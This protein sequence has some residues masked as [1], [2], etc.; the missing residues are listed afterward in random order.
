MNKPK[1][2]VTRR[3]P[4]RVEQQ[5]SDLFD[6]TLNTDDYPLSLSELIDAMQ[7]SDAVLPTVS[8]RITAEVLTVQPRQT[9]IIASFGVGF[10]HIDLDAAKS[11][12]LTVT[13]TPDVL[14]DCTA[15]LAITLMLSLA[16]RA[17]EGE[18]HVRN[19]SWSGWRPTHMMA[20][21]VTGKK[22]GLVGMGRIARA[23]AKRAHQGFEMEVSFYDPFLPPQEMLSNIEA[24]SC[25]SL[26][27][28]LSSSDFISIHCP[29]SKETHHLIDA[30]AISHIQP[31]AFLI[32]TARGDVI[33]EQALV[34]ALN[35]NQIAGAA[36][37]VYEFEPVIDDELLAMDNVVLLP[38]L[39][40]ATLETRE[41]MGM[42]VIENLKAFFAGEQPPDKLI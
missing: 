4:A 11:E 13:N 40:S 30:N 34:T 2:F 31:H 37:D 23:V 22:L 32:N 36:L 8:D 19:G 15:D 12:G 14:T 1:V 7:N 29:G 41:A 26:E 9:Q 20:T 38:H 25:K 39:G 3:W 27:Q 24:N 42:R 10:N 21:R 28:L 33:D 5:L 17:G 6:A 16:R 35:N 18:R